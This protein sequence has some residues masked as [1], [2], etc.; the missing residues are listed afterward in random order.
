MPQ[1]TKD[2]VLVATYGSLKAGFYNHPALGKD[3]VLK[4]KTTVQGV[5]YL[6]GG[7]PHLYHWECDWE[8]PKEGNPK[9]CSPF[10]EN[11]QREHEVEV[12]EINVDSYAF[13]VAMETGAGYVEEELPTEWGNAKIYFNPHDSYYSGLR[14]IESYGKQYA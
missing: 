12:Y 11:L 1:G 4:G 8:S 13:I 5:M 7:Y 6:A 2:R 10:C 9:R 3:A 14:Y